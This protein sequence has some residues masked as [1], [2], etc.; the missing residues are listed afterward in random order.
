MLHYG[1]GSTRAYKETS[2]QGN[3]R[4]FIHCRNA[5][6]FAKCEDKERRGSGYFKATNYPARLL[7]KARVASNIRDQ[8]F[9]W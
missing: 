9:R 6:S 4:L 2:D 8:G 1:W 7:F 5:E 3:R